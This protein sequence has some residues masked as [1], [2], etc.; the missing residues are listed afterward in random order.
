MSE[1]LTRCASASRGATSRWR[2]W[3]RYRSRLR[4]LCEVPPSE[5]EQLAGVAGGADCPAAAPAAAAA[6]PLRWRRA[7]PYLGVMLPYTPLHHLLL[8]EVGFPVVAT[9]GNLTDE[10]IC[11]DE[12][13]AV[14]PSGPHCRLLPGPRPADR[15]ACRRQRGLDRWPVRRGCCAGRGLCA[16]AGAAAHAVPSDPGR[17]RPPEEHGCAEHVGDQ[18]FISQ[19]IGDLETPEALAA[20]ER[21]IADFLRSTVDAGGDRP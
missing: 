9:S 18:V 14:A 12:R 5:A 10:P 19:H 13:D 7:I 3:H 16:A 8:R 1:R 11:T 4:A 20:F 15:P 6:W 21:V 2:S 17:R